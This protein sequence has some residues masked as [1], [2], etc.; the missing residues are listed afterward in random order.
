MDQS[1]PLRRYLDAGM[2]LTQLTQARA[3]ALV[4]EFVSA[5]ELQADQAQAAVADVIERSRQNTERLFEQ[6]RQ[7]LRDQANA[8]GLATKDDISRI[9]E[10]I[11]SLVSSVTSVGQKRGSSPVKDAAGPMPVGNAPAPQAQAAKAPVAT[12]A[13]PKAPAKRSTSATP[14]AAAKKA[15]VRAAKRGPAKATKKTAAKKSRS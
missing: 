11:R 12:V 13:T 4:K 9:E 6:V 8:L 1:N 5:G 15:P 2:A 3:E 7:E 10:Q 14:R